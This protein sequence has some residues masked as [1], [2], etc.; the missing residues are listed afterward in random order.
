MTNQPYLHNSNKTLRPQFKRPTTIPKSQPDPTLTC[1]H[2]W[3]RYKKP[4]RI[5]N[6]KFKYS[7]SFFVVRGCEKC[8]K[9]EYLDYHMG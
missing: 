4:I 8:K 7:S 1:T 2:D 6:I 3:K 9:V 5:E